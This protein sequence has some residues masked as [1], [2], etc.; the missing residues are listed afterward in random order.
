MTVKLVS[1]A[2]QRNTTGTERHGAAWSL[3]PDSCIAS[4]TLMY[5]LQPDNTK[6][7]ELLQWFASELSKY[8]AEATML[9]MS[10]GN[11]EQKA[12]ITK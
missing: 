5:L 3:L 10:G 6:V 9:L 4:D 7:P 2:V 1:S 12:S 11:K 8:D